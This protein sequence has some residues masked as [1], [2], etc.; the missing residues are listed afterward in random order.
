[1]EVRP[2]EPIY[3]HMPSIRPM[4]IS[5]LK[6]WVMHALEA[7]V[8]ERVLGDIELQRQK[9]GSARVKREMGWLSSRLSK[10]ELLPGTKIGN[11]I[12]FVV[13][14]NAALY[15][16]KEV[17]QTH[18]PELNEFI[19]RINTFA[20]RYGVFV[21]HISPHELRDIREDI[22]T[23]KWETTHDERGN[24]IEKKTIFGEDEYQNRRH[25]LL[26]A[27]QSIP[28]EERGSNLNRYG[29]DTGPG[30]ASNIALS[31][32]RGLHDK[33]GY[34]EISP[35]GFP[36]KMAYTLRMSDDT[37]PPTGKVKWQDLPINYRNF[38]LDQFRI[39]REEVKEGGKYR[40]WNDRSGQRARID[41]WETGDRP[42]TSFLMRR[43]SINSL[44]YYST[45]PEED[46][47]YP[48]KSNQSF[49]TP[50]YLINFGKKTT[51][52]TSSNIWGKYWAHKED[53]L[54]PLGKDVSRKIEISSGINYWKI[55]K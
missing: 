41:K 8:G 27:H 33:L 18:T 39:I 53:Y 37:A 20:N 25:P 35:N 38:F 13:V 48:G 15:K 1:M 55:R 30:A 46:V 52:P 7:K 16:D 19:R 5:T 50:S 3:I 4:V 2:E 17:S 31:Y 43:P 47:H 42:V 9:T 34:P 21:H 24:A 36:V 51:A 14:D 6:R 23:E 28:E 22:K 29:F 11:D 45:E 32:I 26:T 10:R 44:Q 12:H 40:G 49:F 54:R